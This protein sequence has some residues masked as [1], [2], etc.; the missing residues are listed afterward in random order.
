MSDEITPNAEP[1]APVSK[2]EF[3]EH[4]LQTKFDDRVLVI[5]NGT[6]PAVTLTVSHA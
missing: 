6:D 1:E 4:G 5:N 2:A 3:D